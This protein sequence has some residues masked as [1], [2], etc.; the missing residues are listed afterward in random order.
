L[1]GLTFKKQAREKIRFRR[2]KKI[3]CR[4]I[5]PRN[6]QSAFPCPSGH[7]ALSRNSN[8]NKTN[9]EKDTTPSGSQNRDPPV[10]GYC[11]KQIFKERSYTLK[12]LSD[13]EQFFLNIRRTK[14]HS[15]V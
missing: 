9:D 7:A 2:I 15:L 11:V 6:S 8:D 3:L 4:N 13:F 14:S 5:R 1:A 12:G 10:L